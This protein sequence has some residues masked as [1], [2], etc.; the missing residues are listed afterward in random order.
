MTLLAVILGQSTKEKEPFVISSFSPFLTAAASF[1][2]S[3]QTEIPM[4]FFIKVGCRLGSEK[5]VVDEL[6][7]IRFSKIAALDWDGQLRTELQEL[8]PEDF[9]ADSVESFDEDL[10]KY[11]TKD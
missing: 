1:T 3:L 2:L 10:T 11:V 6:K 9:V 7:I 4:S 5:L 8:R